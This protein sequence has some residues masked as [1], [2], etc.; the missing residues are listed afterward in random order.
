MLETP[1]TNSYE[2]LLLY[3]EMKH[4]DRH[5]LSCMHNILLYFDV[6]HYSAFDVPYYAVLSYCAV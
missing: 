3:L 5:D 1:K 6:G 2:A 4:A